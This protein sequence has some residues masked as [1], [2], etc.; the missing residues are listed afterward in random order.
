M[1]HRELLVAYQRESEQLVQSPRVDFVVI[2]LQA[3]WY[4]NFVFVK[5]VV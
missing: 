3:A 2:I 5:S 4:L 1:S